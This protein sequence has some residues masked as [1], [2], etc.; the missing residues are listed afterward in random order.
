MGSH[1]KYEI[2]ENWLRENG[3]E[4][5]MVELREYSSVDDEATHSAFQ[6]CGNG[7]IGSVDEEDKK[8]EICEGSIKST[9]HDQEGDCEMRGVHAK[10][11]ILPQTTCIAIPAQCLI[12]VEMGQALDLGQIILA[13]D[14]D[15]DAPKHVFL[16]VFLL[17]DRKNENSFFKP[18][19][20]ILPKTLENIPIF[21]SEE[22][23]KYLEGSHLIQ[24]IKDRNI[25][26]QEDYE[27]ICG[28]APELKEVATLEEFKWARMCVCS[29]NFGL[30][31]NGIR[32]SALVPHAD[33]LNHYRPRQTKWTFDNERQAFTIISLQTIPAGSQVY[34]SYGQKCNHRFLL[35]YGFAIE[36]NTEIDGYSP[37]EVAIE[38]SPAS[39]DLLS[40]QVDCVQSTALQLSK[41][42]FW[43]RDNP[44]SATLPA[45]AVSIT[46]SG[47][48]DF[49]KIFERR[50]CQKRIRVSVSNNENTRA[51]MSMLRVIVA[52]ED[53]LSTITCGGLYMYRT[54]KDVRFAISLRNEKA[55][56]ML[57]LNLV[58]DALSKYPTTLEEDNIALLSRENLP[59]FSNKRNST[60]QV[61]GEKEVLHHYKNLAGIALSVIDLPN[62]EFE[63]SIQE[64]QD[65]FH[66]TI[67]HYCADVIGSVRRE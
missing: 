44:T 43:C 27:A 51:M 2:F 23:L 34:D 61:R 13:S 31:I 20:D 35:N 21:W 10:Q 52:N 26:I 1:D 49:S 4:F 46:S 36:D 15:L 50:A 56:L 62:E 25:A 32:T 16:M 39:L 3:A 57:L 65:S 47:E 53:E 54:C 24:Q 67:V 59:P 19:Y 18:Y 60:I 14:L 48:I 45:E 33:M 29:R 12:T 11:T 22:E 42:D 17:V 38:M 6:T 41:M 9:G 63:S 40:D 58:E 8:E 55:A 37:N 66:Y 7:P 5:D 30:V 28:I 64:L